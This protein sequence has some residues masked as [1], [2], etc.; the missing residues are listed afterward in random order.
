MPD[1]SAYS[2]HVGVATGHSP[3][4]EAQIC[5]FLRGNGIP[6]RVRG[7]ALR[8]THGITVD[9]IGAAEVQVPAQFAQ[10]ARELIA[11]A[12]RGELELADGSGDDSI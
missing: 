7:E 9:G 11:M 12:D 8:I 5:S 3:F 10:A 2:D 6:A 4:E 1:D